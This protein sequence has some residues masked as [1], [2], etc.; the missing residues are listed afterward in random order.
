MFCR[1][2]QGIKFSMDVFTADCPLVTIF[3]RFKGLLYLLN[4]LFY[5]SSYY[6]GFCFI[7]RVT[8][9]SSLRFHL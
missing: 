7:D 5:T 4:L 1:L 9:T 6:T 8:N 3:A 2:W